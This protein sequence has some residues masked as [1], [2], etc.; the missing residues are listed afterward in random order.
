MKGKIVSR[1]FRNYIEKEFSEF[2]NKGGLI[3]HQNLDFFLKGLWFESSAFSGTSFT[4]Q[5][6]IQPLYIPFDDYIFNL[7]D[8]LGHLRNRH[9]R[10]WDYSRDNEI[11]IMEDISDRIKRDAI[12]FFNKMQST[13]DLLNFIRRDIHP[14]KDTYKY[15]VFI[16]SLI[17]LTNYKKAK[18]VILP[19]LKSIKKDFKTRSY[20]QDIYTRVEYL[21]ILLDHKE[22]QSA[23]KLI[24]S[25]QNNT[26]A[27]L[28]LS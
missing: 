18:K 16:N 15:E 12:P 17:L 14:N 21:L 20:L 13:S 3:Y 2:K 26:I 11:E 7:G 25:Y 6:F 23:N 9:D 5:V 10:W 19:F 24:Q 1:L 4:I 28:K 22:F 8:R 27:A